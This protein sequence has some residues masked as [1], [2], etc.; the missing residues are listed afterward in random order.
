[1]RKRSITRQA[2]RRALP[3][4]CTKELAFRRRYPRQLIVDET[5]IVYRLGRWLATPEPG[6]PVKAK[7]LFAWITSPTAKAGAFEITAYSID[8]FASNGAVFD[9][10]DASEGYEAEFGT[11]LVET[12]KDV[13]FDVA[14]YGDIVFYRAAWVS[15]DYK[16]VGIFE[17]ASLSLIDEHFPRYSVILMKAF[18]LEYERIEAKRGSATQANLERRLRAM[19]RHYAR[20]FGAQ[21]MPRR[22]GKEGWLWAPRPERR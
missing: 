4:F 19:R 5:P 17:R 9:A 2:E 3:E 14:A 20:I 16:D 6:F 13:A 11:V 22:W 18:P 10:L 21:S 7:Q 1:M 15:P 12:W 8:D